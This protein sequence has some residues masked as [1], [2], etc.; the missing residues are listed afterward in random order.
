MK[1]FFK[2]FIKSFFKVIGRKVIMKFFK[3]LLMKKAP[4]YVTLTILVMWTVVLVG[5]SIIPTSYTTSK[6][7]KELA[8]KNTLLQAELLRRHEKMDKA[9]MFEFLKQNFIFSCHIEEILCGEISSASKIFKDS[10]KPKE[11]KP[12]GEPKEEPK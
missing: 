11:E 10:L 6:A 7:Q 8:Q 9:K 2:R 5:C 4:V 3:D 12:K 1:K